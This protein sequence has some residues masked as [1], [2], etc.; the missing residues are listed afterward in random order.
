MSKMNW[1]QALLATATA[2]AMWLA[3]TGSASAITVGGITFAEGANLE[4]TTIWENPV[5]TPGAN[6]TGIGIV[7]KI[8]AGS[9]PAGVCW[10]SGNNSRELTFSFLYTLARVED[11]A[12]H[13]AAP[14][15]GGGE[16]TAYFTGG[17]VNFFSDDSTNNGGDGTFTFTA[18]TAP[19]GLPPGQAAD[20]TSAT[21]GTPWLNTV[22]GATGENCPATCFPLGAAT[23]VTIFSHYFYGAGGFADVTDVGGTGLAFL[24]I[25]AG[26]GIANA[27]FNTNTY[28][29]ADGGL[30]DI[31][32]STSFH[33]DNTGSDFLING[34]ASLQTNAINVPEPGSLL[35]FGS[36]LLGLGFAMRRRSKKQ[37]A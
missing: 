17:I 29:D 32:F 14:T 9:C 5:I 25:A 15:I 36:G 26:P 13:L 8:T 23:P 28:I 12:T 33:A 35:L 20:F 16:A 24:D 31:Q 1:K 2:G 21:D 27:Y 34:S 7:E 37:A 19:A 3:A 22:G 11:S 4:T 30:H 18:Y 10:V 6:L